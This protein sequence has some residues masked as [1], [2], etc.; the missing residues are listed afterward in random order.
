[1]SALWTPGPRFFAIGYIQVDIDAN[2][3]AVNQSFPNDSGGTTTVNVGRY[4]EQ[5]MLYVNGT[6]GYWLRHNEDAKGLL[7]GVALVGELHMNQSLSTP[8][9]IPGVFA[10]DGNISILDATAG[11]H[12]EVLGHTLLTLAYCTPITG[13]REFDGQFKLCL[14]RRF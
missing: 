6:L 2:G 7:T 14:N 4:Y 9:G 13:Q 8:S 11:V 5:T 12:M 10:D 1:M 3:D